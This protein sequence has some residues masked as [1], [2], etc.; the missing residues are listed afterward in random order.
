MM[1]SNAH[2][3]SLYVLSSLTRSPSLGKTF[4]F[5]NIIVPKILTG[6]YKVKKAMYMLS[7]QDPKILRWYEGVICI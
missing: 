4:N 6:G 7:Y 1:G 3:R 2:G 5:D